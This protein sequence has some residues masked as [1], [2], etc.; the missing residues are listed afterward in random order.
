MSTKVTSALVYEAPMGAMGEMVAKIFSN[1]GA[2]VK[3]DL[4]NFKEILELAKLP[5]AV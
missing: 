5:A 2:M 1:P 4:Q 3:E